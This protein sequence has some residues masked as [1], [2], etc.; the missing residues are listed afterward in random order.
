MLHL[1]NGDVAA[2]RIRQAAIEGEIVAWQDALHDG[3]VPEGLDDAALRE[4]RVRFIAAEG[5][6]GLETVQAELDARDAALAEATGPVVLW[7]EHDLYDQLQLLQILDRLAGRA[8]AGLVVEA[9]DTPTYLGMLGPDAFRHLFDLRDDVTPESFD[10]AREAWRAFRSPDPTALEE[11]VD[12]N[13]MAMPHLE[14]ALRRHLEE[15]PAPGDGLSRSERQTLEA[16]AGGARTVV[17]AYPAAHHAREEAVFLGDVAFV[18]LLRRLS[19]CPEPLVRRGDGGS[20]RL[21][22]AEGDGRARL[23]DDM[24]AAEIVVT[25]AGRDVLAGEADHVSLNG[26]D[27]W[28][29][30]VHLVGRE[31]PWRWDPGAGCLVPGS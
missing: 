5:W 13:T 18:T 20:F 10:L 27:R 12:G 22:L 6:A 8:D 26:I 14:A 2:T 29:G 24:M 7:F 17:E 15:F 1:T 28:L 11:L 25:P 16:V 3:P 9:I 21:D 19:E 30:G 4:E 23:R 31:V